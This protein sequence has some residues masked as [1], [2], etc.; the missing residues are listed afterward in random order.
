[1]FNFLLILDDLLA[2]F[3]LWACILLNIMVIGLYLAMIVRK[4]DW[5]AIRQIPSLFIFTLITGFVLLWMLGEFDLVYNIF[6][7]I[8]I[9]FTTYP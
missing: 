7:V 8:I 2:R 6:Y 9:F 1:M 3:H 5:L 4:G